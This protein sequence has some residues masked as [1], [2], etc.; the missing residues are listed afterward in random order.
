M[1]GG[2][3]FFCHGKKLYLVKAPANYIINTINKQTNKTNVWQGCVSC[4][5][6]ASALRKFQEQIRSELKYNAIFKLKF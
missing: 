4:V 3:F 2:G 5:M 1:Q 6:N